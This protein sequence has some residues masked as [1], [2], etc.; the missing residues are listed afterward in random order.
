MQCQGTGIT[1]NRQRQ[2]RRAGET[3]LGPPAAPRHVHDKTA[4]AAHDGAHEHAKRQLRGRCARTDAGSVLGGRGSSYRHQDHRRGDPVVEPALDVE[5]PADP[6]RDRRVH[7]H[8]RTQGRIGRRQR[9]AHQQGEPDTHSVEQPERQQGPQ[10]DSQRQPDPQKPQAQAQ[11]SAQVPQPHPGRV[12]EQH[13]HQGDLCQCFDQLSGRH[14]TQRRQ[15]A[16]GQ[17]QP[18]HDEHD[19][20]GDVEPLQPRRQRPPRKDKRCHDRQVR[21]AHRLTSCL[22]ASR[23]AHNRPGPTGHQPR[24]APKPLL[25][26]SPAG[27][28]SAGGIRPAPGEPI[29]DCSPGGRRAGRRPDPDPQP[30]QERS[31]Q[32]PEAVSVNPKTRRAAQQA[33][34]VLSERVPAES[35]VLRAVLRGD[36]RISPYREGGIRPAMR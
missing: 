31:E 11:V 12:R 4:R 17:H 21:S 36:G 30:Q 18:G 19:R 35:G 13:Q 25:T 29:P 16:V 27:Q 32:P 26:G 24:R 28:G 15:R 23:T 1:A 10:A 14:E 9:R 20:G 7:H 2:H 22:T 3:T 6:R 34:S 33:V 8:A 5:Q